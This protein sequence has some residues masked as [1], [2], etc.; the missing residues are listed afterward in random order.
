MSLFYE[1]FGVRSNSEL[2]I[3]FS[4]FGGGSLKQIAH[5]GQCIRSNNFQRWD[6][7]I[8]GNLK[9]Y[10]RLRPPLYDLSKITVPLT[11]HYSVEDTLVGYE[12]IHE[13]ERAL[14]NAV[15]RRIAD[16]NFTHIGF[17]L[18]RSVKEL[19]NDYIVE[20]LKTAEI[21]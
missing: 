8:M 10:G 5:Y 2:F 7:G 16:Y 1:I 14:P 15:S 9:A 13:M 18:R 12:D 20:Q 4:H 21:Q 17:F 19:L 6:Y 3:V 11:L